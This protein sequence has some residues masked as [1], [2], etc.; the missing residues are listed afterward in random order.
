MSLYG[1]TINV[2]GN[3]VYGT[4]KVTLGDALAS[5]ASLGVPLEI[6]DTGEK[7][8]SVLMSIETNDARISFGATGG[9]TGHVIAVGASYS[10]D[11]QAAVKAALL[12]NSAAGSNAVAQITLYF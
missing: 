5:L 8:V 10:M 6:P 12:G 7:A 3:P 2:D 4:Y 1:S 9:S 11:G